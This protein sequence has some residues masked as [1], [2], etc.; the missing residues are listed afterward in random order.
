ME[1]VALEDP[2]VWAARQ[3]Y[4]DENVARR[5]WV[6]EAMLARP[7]IGA[8]ILVLGFRLHCVT[9]GNSAPFS[10]SVPRFMREVA[11]R[12]PVYLD[13]VEIDLEATP[14]ETDDDTDALVALLGDP[15]RRA[16]VVG[17]SL[18]ERPLADRPLIDPDRLANAVFGTAHVRV[19][20]RSAGFGLTDRIGKRF[21]VFNGAVRIWWPGLRTDH[22]DPYDHPLWLAQRIEDDGPYVAQRDIVDLLLRASAG[23]RDADD[24]IPSFAEARRIA[25]TLAR[26]KAAESGQSSEELLALYEAEN[27]RLLQDLEDVKAEQA[28]LL[29]VADADL[30][31]ATAERDEARAEI[32]VLRARLTEMMNA[33]QTRDQQSVIPIPDNFDELGD[34]ADQYLGNG[35]ELLPRAINAAKKSVFDDPPL[36]YQALLLMRNVY[37][38]MRRDS[39]L[40]MKER[41]DSGLRQL[42][43][44]CTPTHA[45]PRAGEFASDYF[46]MYDGHRTEIDMHLKGSNSRDP[47]YCFRVYF[48]W[49]DEK[50]RLV[51][52]SLP[53]HL[54]SRLT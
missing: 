28:E 15:Q 7:S 13:G 22:D 11:R 47:R 24:A 16:P 45:G 29:A 17:I 1:T 18:A 54:D 27:A 21:S 48:F 19:L 49:C 4:Q 23:R 42:G 30:K 50:M 51:V 32:H 31:T 52:A 36:A 39:S 43:L 25:S 6:T 8:N 46:V 20:S 35:V 12:Y 5:S 44:D 3:D 34:W 2:R 40:G 41:W 38:P 26:E 53:S 14:V 10:R 37:V 9:L 33:L